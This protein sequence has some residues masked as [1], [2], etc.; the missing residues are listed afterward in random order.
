VKLART[1]SRCVLVSSRVRFSALEFFPKGGNA[2]VR[3]AGNQL[4][5]QRSILG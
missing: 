2:M 5:E 1:L 4:A 3:E